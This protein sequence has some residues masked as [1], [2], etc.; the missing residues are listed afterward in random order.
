MKPRRKQRET[1]TH[2]GLWT[3]LVFTVCVGVAIFGCYKGAMALVDEWCKD[4]PDVTKEDAFELPE[5][6]VIYASDGKTVLAEMYLEKREP[7]EMDQVSN[8]VT[9]GTIAT[10]D[11]RF[12]EHNGVDLQGIV[13]AVFVN[14]T[15]GQE[16]ASTITQQ[17]IR[18]TVLLDEMT[19]I[20]LKRKVREIELA[21]QLEKALAIKH[22]EEGKSPEEAKQAAKDDILMMYLNT[23]NYGD[24]CYGIQAAAQH[25]YSVNATDLTIAQAATLIGIPNSPTLYNPVLNPDASLERRNV[26]LT[27]M[28]SNGVITQEE[29][30][31]AVSEGLGLNVMPEVGNNGI[32][33]YPWFTS[34]VR[35]QIIEEYPEEAFTGGLQVITT[36]DVKMQ[37]HAEDAVAEQYESGNMVSSDQELALTLIDPHTGFIKAMIGGKDYE[38]D[39]YN[40][41]TSTQGNQ[42]GSTFKAFTLTDAIEKGISPSTNMNCDGPVEVY[43]SSIHNYGGQDY[44]TMTIADMT[45]ISSNTGFIRLITDE[46]SGVTP[47]SVAKV[48]TRLGLNEENLPLVP[49]LT[50]G[51]GNANTTEMA[52]AYGTF[53]AQGVYREP[54]A[55]IKVTDRHGNVKEEIDPE[56]GAKGKEVLDESVAY[57]VTEVLQGVIYKSMGTA[58]AA[59]LP[60][61]QIAAGKTGTTDNWHD[62]WFVGYTP[63]LSCA[64]WTGSRGNNVELYTSTWCQEVWRDVMSGCLEGQPIEEFKP[65]P[66]PDYGSDYVG[67]KGKN[68]DEEEEKDK[69]EEEETTEDEGTEEAPADTSEPAAPEP[70]TPEPSEPVAPEPSE[71]VTPEPSE[72]VAPEPSEPVTPEPSTP[73][74]PDDGA[75]AASLDD[76]STRQAAQNLAA[77][78][79][80]AALRESL[81]SY[82]PKQALLPFAAR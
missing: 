29:Y 71:P 30:D 10:E 38:K 70:V 26:V 28:L 20:S 2:A 49:T 76:E 14:L 68:E 25:Y 62:L 64:V 47:E 51:V 12:R 79:K 54:V 7:V 66:A 35:E 69:E 32:Y 52:A 82:P 73:T 45:A 72:P 22:E 74:T 21:T 36:L 75:A 61:G 77:K 11:E 9:E 23:I 16:G 50:L 56:R 55:I 46:T 3:V 59:A 4:L 41:A 5:K 1:R 34:Y 57:A 18:N 80:L 40:I 6:S 24:G 8:W 63:Q 42:T 53:A 37:G 33:K 48:A 44:G 65:A 31:A 58:S 67:S 60:S 78:P 17:Y 43:G 13:R 27:R 39:Q 19:E 81:L 15:G